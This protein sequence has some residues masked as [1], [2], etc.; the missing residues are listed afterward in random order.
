MLYLK[1]S[2]GR[3][4]SKKGINVLYLSGGPDAGYP[5]DALRSSGR[6]P[7]FPIEEPGDLAGGDGRLVEGEEGSGV[8]PGPAETAF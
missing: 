1:S 8:V 3:D 5:F 2:I 4:I 6:T 7:K